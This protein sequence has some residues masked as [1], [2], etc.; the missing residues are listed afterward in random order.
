MIVLSSFLPI[1]SFYFF[2]TSPFFFD[3]WV[4]LQILHRIQWSLHSHSFYKCPSSYGNCVEFQCLAI[5]F[6]I[7][8]LFREVQDP[9]GKKLPSI[10]PASSCRGCPVR[11]GSLPRPVHSFQLLLLPIFRDPIQLRLHPKMVQHPLET[12]WKSHPGRC[13][14]LLGA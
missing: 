5:C 8:P 6:P 14:A 11:S 13:M 1:N 2:E 9:K 10:D 12:C 7:H 3:A 4:S